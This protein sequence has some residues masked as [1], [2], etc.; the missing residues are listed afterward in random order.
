MWVRLLAARTLS[1]PRA[2]RK[3]LMRECGRRIVRHVSFAGGA[4]VR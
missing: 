1:G 4:A 3:G 2:V